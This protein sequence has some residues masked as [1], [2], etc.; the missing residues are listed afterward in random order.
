MSSRAAGCAPPARR[1]ARAARRS[2]SRSRTSRGF[3]ATRTSTSAA[4]L[5]RAGAGQGLGAAGGGHVHV[6][7]GRGGARCRR[8]S[9]PARRAS[10]CSLLTADR[11]PELRENGAGQTIDQLKLFGTAAK[12]FFEVGV[13][14]C[15]ADPAALDP[16]ACLPCL[17]DRLAGPAGCRAPELPAARAARRSTSADRRRRAAVALGV[18]PYVARARRRRRPGARPGA[19]LGQLIADAPGARSS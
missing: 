9:R 18:C 10:R 8:S 1:P 15:D 6:G 14:D 2:C 11:P 17:L 5:L 3:A 12:W 4:R 16:H 7:H 13:H 19:A